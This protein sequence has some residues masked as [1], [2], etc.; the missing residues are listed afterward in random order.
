MQIQMECENMKDLN[1]ILY[2][3]VYDLVYRLFF[4]QYNF[5][6]LP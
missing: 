1:K 6:T 3:Y 2:Y 4:S 5:R